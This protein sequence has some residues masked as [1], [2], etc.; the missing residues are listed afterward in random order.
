MYVH[1]YLASV[2][3]LITGAAKS[4]IPEVGISIN[5]LQKDI[6]HL[7]RRYTEEDRRGIPNEGRVILRSEN[8]PPEIYTTDIISGILK[9]EGKG[10]F[11]SRTAVLG[12]LQQGGIPTPTDRIRA[13]RLAVQC[14]DWIQ[15]TANACR[16]PEGSSHMSLGIAPGQ[17]FTKDPKH[18]AVVGSRGDS[19]SFSPVDELLS[20][21]DIKNRRSKLAGWLEV[22]HITRILAKYEYH[23]EG[24]MDGVDRQLDN[25]VIDGVA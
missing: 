15:R 22:N 1:S 19:I 7:V 21:V 23:E 5:S 6:R 8:T 25:V 20:E 3:G 4:Y 18:I 24:D 14:I 17:V 9:A 13:T 2:G 11:D 16:L 10:V 12:H